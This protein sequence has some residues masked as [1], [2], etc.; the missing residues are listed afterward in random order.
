MKNEKGI[1]LVTLVIT[2]VVLAIIASIT[3]TGGI[4]AKKNVKDTKSA[5]LKSE[6][7]QVQQIVL[8]TD[9]KYKQTK[10]SNILLGEKITFNEAKTALQEISGSLSLR[11]E[12]YDDV[13]NG[14][15]EI[16]YYKIDSELLEQLGITGS[17]QKYIINYS[18]GEVFNYQTKTT[19]NG[20][21]L[22][23][24]VE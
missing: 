16:Y 23:K 17:E 15:I 4:D 18:T 2:I 21:L 9:I 8:E 14:D 20:D 24:N 6:I 12:N 3:I 10:N 1:T 19:S 22:Y 5:V 13:S 11:G 7:A